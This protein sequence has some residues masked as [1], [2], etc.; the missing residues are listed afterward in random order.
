MH[1]DLNYE[2]PLRTGIAI[3]PTIA[4]YGILKPD[5]LSLAKIADSKRRQRRW[6]TRSA[7]TIEFVSVTDLQP[8]PA[9][10]RSIIISGQDTGVCNRHFGCGGCGVSARK[11][12][13][14]GSNW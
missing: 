9:R 3:N 12:G 11:F 13:A 5:T 1:A 4:G 6:S 2:Y 8:R 10:G 7:L 14:S